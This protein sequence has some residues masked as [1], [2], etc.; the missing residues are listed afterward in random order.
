VRGLLIE[1]FTRPYLQRALVEVLI[2]SVVAGAIS[3]HVLLRRLAF[4]GDALTHAV[5]PGI[6]VAFVLDRSLLLGALVAG[7][8][9]AVLLTGAT[10]IRNVDT[11]AALG[12]LLG[13]FFSVGVL[14]VSTEQSYSSDLLALLFGRVLTV[15]VR[16][17]VE[18]AI[19]AVL[20]LGAL[21]FSHKE[22][23]LRAF[24]P[25]G[26]EALGYRS[27]GLDLLLNVLVALV[28]VAA[29]RSVGTVLVVAILVIPAA[30]A[31]LLTSRL[32]VLFAVSIGIAA[33]SGYLGLVASYDASVHHGVRLASGA[34]IVVVL[35]VA[36]AVAA[37]FS[38][39]RAVAAAR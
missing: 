1:P 16:Q 24:D 5:F 37:A 7:L 2:L 26:A 6:A 33:A 32:G 20:V 34:T 35:S 8:M 23:V 38:K 18:T 3:V 4:L 19:L 17:I 11:D 36:F 10:R 9:A 28:T 27:V 25:L 30:A 39:A 13:L 12:V 14:V 31:R 21:A 22:L 15:D 29:V